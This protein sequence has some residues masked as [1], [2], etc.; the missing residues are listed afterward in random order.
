MIVTEGRII[1]S[2]R[3]WQYLRNGIVDLLLCS[4]ETICTQ[5]EGRIPWETGAFVSVGSSETD[6][7]F[8]TAILGIRQYASLQSLEAVPD[9][10]NRRL[11]PW[12]LPTRTTAQLQFDIQREPDFDLSG[13]VFLVQVHVPSDGERAFF[14]KL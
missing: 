10:V 5:N 13:T 2:H 8:V 11:I 9:E 14:T 1:V 3:T 6:E 12:A 4:R 7:S